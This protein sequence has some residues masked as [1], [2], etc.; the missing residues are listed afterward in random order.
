MESHNKKLAAIILAAPKGGEDEGGSDGE[1]GMDTA[2]DELIAA[3]HKK[4]AKAV[5]SALRAAFE[6]CEASPH[7][8]AEAEA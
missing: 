7:E 6:I 5:V 1:N 3:I 8:E 2:A 4:D